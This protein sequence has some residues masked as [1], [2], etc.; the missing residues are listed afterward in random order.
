MKMN[1]ALATLL[2]LSL[3]GTAE[4]RGVTVTTAKGGSFV[5]S[6]SCAQSTGQLTCQAHA[7]ATGAQG[8]SATRDR[9][10]TAT[11]GQITSTLSGTR[12]NGQ[13]FSR[14]SEVKH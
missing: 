13:G 7:T 9:S 5:R 10:T 6:G 3:S 1:L 2:V 11:A 12:A 4:A 8:R 14:A